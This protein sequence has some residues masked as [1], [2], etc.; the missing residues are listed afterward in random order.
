MPLRTEEVREEGYLYQCNLVWSHHLIILLKSAIPTK[1]T[2]IHAHVFESQYSSCFS[3]LLHFSIYRMALNFSLS[4]LLCLWVLGLHMCAC[5]IQ[6]VHRTSMEIS[7][8]LSLSLVWVC[9]SLSF[10]SQK[11]CINSSNSFISQRIISANLGLMCFH[12]KL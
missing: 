7:V 8:C 10:L 1:V 3:F 11:S 2:C 5:I 6:S 4:S 9:M 12:M